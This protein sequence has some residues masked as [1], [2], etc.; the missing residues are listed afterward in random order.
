MGW[1]HC[2]NGKDADNARF[3]NSA[4]KTWSRKRYQANDG[5]HKDAWEAVGHKGGIGYDPGADLTVSPG[6]PGYAN[7]ALMTQLV[8]DK[9]TAVT[10]DDVAFAGSIS[11]SEVMVDAGPR[12]NLVQWIE[13]YNS[14]MSEAINIKD[15]E[16]EIRN[17]TD[18]VESYV[19]SSFVF[20]DAYILPN[21]TLLIVSGS[22]TNDVADNRVY[23]LYQHHRRALGL[24]NRRSV[25]LSP[26]GFYLKLTD[27][28]E[29]FV[30]HAGN[31]EVK[32]ATRTVMWELPARNP[33]MRQSLVRQYGTR[34]ID[35]TPDSADD[36][37]MM[38]SWKQSDLVG[39]GISFYGHRDDVSTPGY[40]LG[41]PLP[42]S[43]SKFRP[44]RNQETSHV[45]ITW[46]TE[47]EL[48]NAG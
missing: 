15:W 6:T 30:D 4:D 24:T 12:W 18:E 35:G 33:D 37:T 5:H 11:I 3:P 32:G 42:V 13:L 38:E 40:R 9:N 44:V 47:S 19:D 48:N 41:G 46:I 31:V 8:D 34:D 10:T 29:E 21:Q 43:L 14:S 16:L 23:N 2:H 28:N 7:N 1:T 20:N 27:K 22:G 39:V 26:S 36:G 45:D 25:L 17:A